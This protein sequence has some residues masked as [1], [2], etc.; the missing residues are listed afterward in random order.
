MK[1]ELIKIEDGKVFEGDLDQFS[2]CFFSFPEN[3][4]AWE[5]YVEIKQWAKFH[6]YKCE[7]IDG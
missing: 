1:G 5:K 6:S 4:S 2:D 7:I 3:F